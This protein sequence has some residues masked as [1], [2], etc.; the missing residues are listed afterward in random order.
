M[1]AD[2]RTLG[3]AQRVGHKAFHKRCRLI[4]FIA[5]SLYHIDP[6]KIIQFCLN[7]TVIVLRLETFKQ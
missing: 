1:G 3:V 4:S 6:N 5:Y 2:A 7:S